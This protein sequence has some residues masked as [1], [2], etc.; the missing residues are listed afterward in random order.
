MKLS[1][2]AADGSTEPEFAGP[3]SRYEAAYQGSLMVSIRSQARYST[4]EL[5][6]STDELGRSPTDERL[7]TTQLA[8]T[9]YS[10]CNDRGA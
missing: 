6:C 9:D 3:S 5:G 4:D 10:G 1:V 8:S 7:G 2:S